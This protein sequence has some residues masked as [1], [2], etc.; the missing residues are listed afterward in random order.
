MSVQ[1]SGAQVKPQLIGRRRKNVLGT[2]A[3]S[4]NATVPG[5]LPGDVAATLLSPTRGSGPRRADL[6]DRALLRPSVAQ[7]TS[8]SPSFP[9][10]AD[11]G[12]VLVR[13]ANLEIDNST[14]S[15]NSTGGSAASIYQ[16]GGTLTVGHTTISGNHAH[17]PRHADDGNV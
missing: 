13:G 14:L 4:R 12:G 17:D 3:R 15:G 1:R 5:G 6:A 7:A 9:R 2:G 11:A 8:P 10:Q 16:I